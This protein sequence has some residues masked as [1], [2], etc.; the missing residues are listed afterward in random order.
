MHKEAYEYVRAQALNLAFDNVVEFGSLNINGSVRSLFDTDSYYGIDLQAGPGVD[1]IADAVTWKSPEGEVD[2]IVCCEVLEHAPDVP[3]II[4]NAYDNLGQN[5]LLIIT[6]ATNPREPHSAVDGG[7]I[8]PFEHYENVEPDEL[9]ALFQ[10][11][12]GI[13]D[14]KVSRE[15]GDLYCV[16]RKLT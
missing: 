11:S 15:R 9:R 4:E 3:G 13:V 16:A 14:L 8:R 10:G 12:F 2:C 7:P 1:E 5:G 6:C